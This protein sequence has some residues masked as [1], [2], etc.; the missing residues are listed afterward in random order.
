M[1]MQFLNGITKHGYKF[2]VACGYE[3][4]K[5]VHACLTIPKTQEDPAQ[6]IQLKPIKEEVDRVMK[7]MSVKGYIAHHSSVTAFA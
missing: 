3:N 2:I 7:E 1:N 6:I 5:L 4:D